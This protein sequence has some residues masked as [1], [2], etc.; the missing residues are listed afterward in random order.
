[1]SDKCK[2][3]ELIFTD[4]SGHKIICEPYVFKPFQITKQDIGE[5][6]IK[7]KYQKPYWKYLSDEDLQGM[8]IRKTLPKN[9]R[10]YENPADIGDLTLELCYRLGVPTKT[11]DGEYRS[12]F[13]IMQDI[14]KRLTFKKDA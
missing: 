8:I 13:D 4:D 10:K 9:E 5:Y 1:M 7:R 14:S 2:I 12:T 6:E 3:G 11:N